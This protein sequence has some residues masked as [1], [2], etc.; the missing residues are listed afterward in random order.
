VIA[1]GRFFSIIIFAI[2][3]DCLLIGSVFAGFFGSDDVGKSGLDFT[4]GY[5]I[6]TVTTM[7][8]QVVSLP[9]P[10][11]KDNIIV[12][13][14]S[15]NQTVNIAVGPGSYWEKKG[16]AINLNDNI[17]VKGS[18]AQGQDGKSYVLAQKLVNKTTGAQVD[19]R[20][21]KGEPTWSGRNTS[22][23]RMESPA[24]GMRNQGGG[25]MMRGGGGMMRR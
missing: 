6:N 25:G 17:S 14:K 8:G 20:N 22:S 23:T 5:D 7:S 16:I 3:L 18:K 11:E 15:G 21:D 24:G 9:H 19:L 13:I 10:G 2:I 1:T 12:E 4:S